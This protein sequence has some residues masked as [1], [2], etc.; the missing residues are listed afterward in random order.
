MKRKRVLCV[1]LCVCVLLGGM[2]ILYD[3]DRILSEINLRYFNFDMYG[4]TE[5]IVKQQHQMYPKH[6]IDYSIFRDNKS[7]VYFTGKLNIV[8]Y[9]FSDSY[10]YGIAD[11]SKYGCVNIEEQHPLNVEE[12]QPSRRITLTFS[13]NSF[14]QTL[15]IAA[16]LMR[17]PDIYR[18]EP[19]VLAYFDSFQ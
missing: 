6:F 2:Y 18:V 17:R 15:R 10:D 4:T 1:V 19:V 3:R 13:T 11:F 8:L 14:R 12:G 16:R 5:D 7:T 9:T